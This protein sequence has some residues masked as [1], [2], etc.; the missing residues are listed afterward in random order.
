M[1]EKNTIAKRVSELFG[2]SEKEYLLD[3]INKN[4][5]ARKISLE[6]GFS[7][8]SVAKRL[9]LYAKPNSRKWVISRCVKNN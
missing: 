5:S 6:L 1:S 3:R 7:H 2:M 4:W 8:V 9:S